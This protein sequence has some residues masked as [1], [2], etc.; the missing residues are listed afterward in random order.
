MTLLNSVY[1]D[2]YNWK[3]A[4]IQ[5][6]MNDVISVELNIPRQP[7]DV[8][9]GRHVTASGNMFWVAHQ[10]TCDVKVLCY[11]SVTC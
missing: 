10:T 2:I 1:E 11:T 3:L 4:E 8:T 7:P 6:R 9:R 5:S